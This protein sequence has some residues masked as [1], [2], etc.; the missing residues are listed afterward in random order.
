MSR[1]M[2]TRKWPEC[3]PLCEDTAISFIIIHD[4]MK[5]VV[6]NRKSGL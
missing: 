1:D 4:G 2:L 6:V 3:L 5:G